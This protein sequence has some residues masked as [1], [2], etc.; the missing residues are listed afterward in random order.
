M[1]GGESPETESAVTPDGSRRLHG[2]GH[3][4]ARDPESEPVTSRR[5]RRTPL[6]VDPSVDNSSVTSHSTYQRTQSPTDRPIWCEMKRRHQANVEALHGKLADVPRHWL[7][8]RFLHN[9]FFARRLIRS[10]MLLSA[11]LLAGYFFY[12]AF[13]GSWLDDHQGMDS[14]EYENCRSVAKFSYLIY[15]TLPAAIILTLPGSGLRAFEPFKR[16]DPA[17]K[18]RNNSDEGPGDDEDDQSSAG[19]ATIRRRFVFQL[20]EVLAVFMLLFDV[21]LVLYFLYVL[22][23]GA[24]SSCGSFAAQIFTIGA[25]FCYA[26][27]FSVLYYFTRYREHIKMQLGAFAENDQTGDLRKHVDL[28]SVKRLDTTKKMIDVVRTRL[29]YATRRGDLHEMREILEYAKE[30][31][32]MSEEIGFPTKFYTNLN[33]SARSPPSTFWGIRHRHYANI[34]ELRGKISRVPRFWLWPRFLNNSFFAR[35]LMFSGLLLSIALAWGVTVYNVKITLWLADFKERNPDNYGHCRMVVVFSGL[36]YHMLPVAVLLLLPGS[37]L[38][39]FE[40]FKRD[41]LELRTGADLEEGERNHSSVPKIRRRL[42]FQLCEI[43]AVMAL[44]YDA[45]LVVYFLRVLFTGAIYACDSY[46]MHLFT[47]GGAVCYVGLFVVL[48]YFARYREHIKMQL[49]AFTESD[50]TGDVRK[51]RIDL[52]GNPNSDKIITVIRTRLYYATRRGDLQEMRE[53]LDHARDRGLTNSEHGFPRKV[54]E[55]SFHGCISHARRMD[56]RE[57]GFAKTSFAFPEVETGE[58]VFAEAD[59]WGSE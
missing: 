45:A 35:R 1:V 43:L 40:P 54:G 19:V 5:V 29:Y 48:Y 36:I 28:R 34:R 3:G 12:E 52:N 23:V 57:R 6:A 21:G 32:L 18:G 4:A 26:G 31:G 38:R 53:I 27:L 8:V 46:E 9:S 30:R 37:G 42:V 11:G 22:F 50:Q 41:E 24:L 58:H 17:A 33:S 7:W 25:A 10:G 15:E 49:G 16:E 39:T 14:D 44:V 47:L 2:G 55:G 59:G 56:H 13:V 20:C 51:H